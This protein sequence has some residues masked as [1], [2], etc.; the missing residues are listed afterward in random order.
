MIKI[1]YIL[2]EAETP[3]PQSNNS[4]PVNN[5]QNNNQSNNNQ[6]NNNSSTTQEKMSL[7]DFNRQYNQLEADPLKTTQLFVKF[8]QQYLP[9]INQTVW[10]TFC[11]TNGASLA[12]AV[13]NYG[14]GIDTN[15]FIQFILN[16]YNVNKN[17]YPFLKKPDPYKAIVNMTVDG[18]IDVKQL[19]DTS[20]EKNQLR[21]LINPSLYNNSIADI[22]WMVRLYSWFTNTD[23]VRRR[24]I[25]R[26]LYVVFFVPDFAKVIADLETQKAKKT[27]TKTYKYY[28]LNTFLTDYFATKT[29]N[30]DAPILQDCCFKLR[31]ALFTNDYITQINND[32]ML[33]RHKG[34]QDLPGVDKQDV[35]ND[36]EKIIKDV[37]SWQT[38]INQMRGNYSLY[39]GE[40][41]SPSTINDQLKLFNL[42]V[43]GGE[44]TL[45]SGQIRKT[46]SI[47][48]ADDNDDS[49]YTPRN[50]SR[51]NFVTKIS[52][53]QAVRINNVINNNPN[54]KGFINQLSDL[55][56]NNTSGIT[57][58]ITLGQLLD[59]YNKY[60]NEV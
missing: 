41:N 1:K 13:D 5:N 45:D 43:N 17:L 7:D 29:D 4:Q 14:F 22:V 19:A 59:I 30:L 39:S 2:T 11:K 42:T 52:G 49:S 35:V 54:I 33:E 3:N 6:Q 12:A 36:H 47:P 28:S 18:Y 20:N 9:S 8:G 60:N 50:A 21:I 24:V 16:Y 15:P 23:D 31:K 26:K 51:G 37:A 58:N 53:S 55:F 10:Q 27:G 25:N 34:K 32:Q 56:R 40:I 44:R 46:N 57:K 48:N 38:K